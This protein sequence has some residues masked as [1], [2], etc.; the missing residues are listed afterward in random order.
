MAKANGYVLRLQ[1]EREDVFEQC[2][3]EGRVFGE[4]VDDFSHSRAVPLVCFVVS[5]RDEISYIG[6]A[7]RGV[8]SGTAL[9][10]L[11]VDEVIEVSPPITIQELENR[12]PN[13]HRTSKCGH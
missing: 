7:R 1:K 6:Q 13:C 10:R 9:T 4:P 11:N 12:V 8:K 2:R 5:R 3:A